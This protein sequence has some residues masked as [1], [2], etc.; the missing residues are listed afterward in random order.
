MTYLV[1]ILVL[2]GILFLLLAR[3]Q[4]AKTGLPEGRIVYTDSGGWGRLE[5]PLYSRARM[6]TGKPDYL[7]EAEGEFIPVEV[8]SSRAPRRPYDTHVYQLAA[9]CML[10]E[11]NYGVR[12]DYGIIQYADRTF[13]VDYTRELEAEVAALLT[14]MR[15]DDEAKSLD[16]SHQTPARCRACGYRPVCDQSLV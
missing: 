2:V 12:P 14:A 16:R 5:R 9:Y 6:L 4:R 11:D 8:K 15:A 3:R 10:V 13:A 7:V 1:P